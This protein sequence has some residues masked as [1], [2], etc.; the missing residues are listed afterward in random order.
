MKRQIIG[1]KAANSLAQMVSQGIDYENKMV[2]LE[3]QPSAL[4]AGPHSY[5][6][7]ERKVWVG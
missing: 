3:K 4:R 1:E 5:D 7:W 6:L 2:F